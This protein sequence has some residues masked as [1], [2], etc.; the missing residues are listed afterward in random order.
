MG[1]DEFKAP[2]ATAHFSLIRDFW[3]LYDTFSLRAR[4]ITLAIENLRDSFI[5]CLE[6]TVGK[7]DVLEIKD[8]WRET[9]SITDPN[10]LIVTLDGGILYR[11]PDFRIEITRACI[12]I[13]N[14]IKGPYLRLPR[15]FAPMLN[16]Q[17]LM[18]QE[19]FSRSGKQNIVLCDDGIGTGGTFRRIIQLCRQLE[20]PVVSVVALTNPLGLTDI[21]GVPVR[22]LDIQR[23][24]GAWL[25]E[26]D[27]FW[28]LPRSGLSISEQSRF[29]TVGGVPY[30]ACE[31]MAV[32]RIGVPLN[33]ARFFIETALKINHTFFLLH[34][35]LYGRSIN[36]PDVPRLA[37]F[38]EY[39]IP[40]E[41]PIREFLKQL[42]ESRELRLR[43]FGGLYD[44]HI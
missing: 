15:Q 18:L 30:T 6:Q 28:G 35:Q 14:S 4:E 24:N 10:S 25:N 3:P 39:N 16:Q 23:G 34:E 41:K 44:D 37:F 1:N 33:K 27:L 42:R 2:D 11:N 31:E 8:I 26:R 43:L 19:V 40:T 22:I 12:S 13:A 38:L 29:G 21:D 7:C 36:F 20:L 17:A 5:T 32:E 9:D